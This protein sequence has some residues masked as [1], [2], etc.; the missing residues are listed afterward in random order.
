MRRVR[1]IVAMLAAS[2]LAGLA[3]VTVGS[4]SSLSV[5]SKSVTTS[6]TCSIITTN[7]TGGVDAYVRQGSA[8][9]NFGTASSA[10]VAS[11]LT[12]SRRIYLRF[13][14]TVCSPAIPSSATV[15]NALLRINSSVQPALACRTH[16]VFRV[17]SAWTETG[18]T[19][20]T[21]P[22]GTALNNPP[23]GE[24]TAG[25]EIGDLCAT[26]S[27]NGYVTGW[28]VT[29]DVDAWIK[30]TATNNGWM[31]RDDSEALL[32]PTSTYRTREANSVTL[33]PWLVITY[34]P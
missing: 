19:W 26:N 28:N 15:T 11:S 6:R 16:D 22:F 32:G 14:L 8:S 18:I 24:R 17:G 34:V 7:S 4:A 25:M 21:Q 27:G 5:S 31:I 20:N 2:A 10:N 13:D 9:S 3:S 29:S 30:G 23:S 1:W 12:D 33:D